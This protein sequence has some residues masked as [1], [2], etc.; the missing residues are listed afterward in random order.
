MSAGAKLP[1]KTQ[2]QNYERVLK[3]LDS[4]AEEAIDVIRAGLNSPDWNIKIRC[5]QIVLNKYLPDKKTKEVTGKDGG[6]IEVTNTSKRALVLEIVDM[7]DEHD[8]DIIMERIEKNGTFAVPQSD[9][10][11]EIEEEREIRREAE[12]IIG[13]ERPGE[14]NSG[15]ES[16]QSNGDSEEC[17]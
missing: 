5:A 9:S 4:T 1:T 16:D 15:A 8:Q 6:P 12:N 11:S 2:L 7:L 10:G 14:D 17:F 3:K 13:G